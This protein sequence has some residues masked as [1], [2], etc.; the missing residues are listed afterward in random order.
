MKKQKRMKTVVTMVT[1]AVLLLVVVPLALALP[2]SDVPGGYWAYAAIDRISNLHI[3]AGCGSGK[4]CPEQNVTRAQMAGFINNLTKAW[5]DTNEPYILYVQ[6][7]NNG[8]GQSGIGIWSY[9]YQDQGVWGESD[10]GDGVYGSSDSGVGVSGAAFGNDA[11]N[12]AGVSGFSWGQGP[13]VKG[14]SVLGD[15]AYFTT[16]GDANSDAAVNAEVV[17]SVSGAYGLIVNSYTN[18]AGHFEA[19]ANDGVYG[20][21]AGS[22]QWG[23]WGVSVDSIAVYG[24]TEVSG[25]YGLYT[26]DKIYTG[27]GCVGCTSMLIAQN[28]GDGALEPGDVVAVVG[29]AEGPTEFYARPVLLVRKAD[30]ALGGSVVGVVEGRYVTVLATKEIVHPAT[31]EM[32]VP[33]TVGGPLPDLVTVTEEWVETV[34]TQDAHTSTDPAAAGEK[35]TVVYRGIVQV[36]AD[37]SAGAIQVGDRLVASGTAGQAVL[38]GTAEGAA[39]GMALE[40]LAE[41]QGLIWVLVDMQ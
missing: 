3:T 22:N 30:A 25:G 34:A 28:G 31:H 38:A 36:K 11:Y 18:D 7:K 33:D 35:L 14:S 20:R 17:S 5:N 6:N 4:Y 21:A 26:S 12:D 23:V 13:G 27:G 2:F 9:S 39:L 41:G 1:L 40:P 29:I 16:W 8:S 19:S 15:A 10:L 37:A 24:D 32:A